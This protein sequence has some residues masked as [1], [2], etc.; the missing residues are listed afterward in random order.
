[1]NSQKYVK[2]VISCLELELNKSGST[3]KGK[4]S[5]PMQANYH[6]EL[7][8]SPLLDS[9]QAN[10]Y[11]SHIGTLRWMVE[12]G[13]IDIF[14]NVSVLS[15]FLA[16]PRV[17][18][19]EQV[20]H[21]FAYLKHH[22][23]TN[24]VF[25]P[26]FVDWDESQFQTFDW[27]DFYKGASES[28][29]PNAPEPWGNPVQ[30]NVFV[31]ANHAGNRVTRRSHTGILLY[32][33]STPIMWYNKAQSTVESSTFGS[34]AMRIAVDLI[35]SVRYKLRMFGVPLQGTANIFCYNKSVVTN[36]TVPTSTLKKKHDS[37]AYHRIR[38]AVA[39]F[40]ICIAK[41]QSKENLADLLTK[42]F[43]ASDL[44]HM[45]QRILGSKLKL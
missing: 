41:V 36:S 8:V 2:E 11:A 23:Q 42:P 12:L 35:E 17:C 16:Q 39:A 20:L 13:R 26:H 9:D 24:L 32:L 28:V 29:P 25:D 18:H 7:D 5:M 19:M 22:E 38:E 33:N 10:Y 27:T 15:S 21:I 31:D 40:L 44:K 34:V 14:I 37:I 30:M 43:S 4:P 1:M 3:L 6:P 45:V